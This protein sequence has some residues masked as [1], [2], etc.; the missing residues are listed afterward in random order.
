MKRFKAPTV[1]CLPWEA[2]QR[3]VTRDRQEPI[4]FS[5]HLVDLWVLDFQGGLL[6]PFHFALPI[7]HPWMGAI[8]YIYLK[9]RMN[10]F[11]WLPTRSLPIVELSSDPKSHNIYSLGTKF[12]HIPRTEQRYIRVLFV[13]KHILYPH[14]Y[15]SDLCH[16]K[17]RGYMN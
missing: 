13:A 10:I 15:W 14:R 9:S 4:I 3:A 6:F 1:I 8:S 2:V 11:T 5:Q 16:W 17:I 7:N 12:M